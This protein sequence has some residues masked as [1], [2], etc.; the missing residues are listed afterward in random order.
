MRLSRMQVSD[1]EGDALNLAAA[2]YQF[3][4]DS[5]Q[6]G[7]WICVAY[8]DYSW[9]TC[10]FVMGPKCDPVINVNDE[11][12]VCK[13]DT[14]RLKIRAEV[15]TCVLFSFT[16]FIRDLGSCLNSTG[17]HLHR[18]NSFEDI[19]TKDHQLVLYF[20]HQVSYW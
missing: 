1:A 17:R 6:I 4:V 12:S 5:N 15:R 10:C 7:K 11:D 16:S 2:S 19:N 9:G 20:P 13:M 8:R 3:Q 14:E 18:W